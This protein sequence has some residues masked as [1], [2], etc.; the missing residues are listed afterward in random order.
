M[1][2]RV[3]IGADALVAGEVALTGAEHH[4]VARVRR[5]AVGDAITAFDGAGRRADGVIGAMT[6]DRTTLVLAAVVREPAPVPAIQSLVPL[7]KGDRLD[8]CVEKLAEV[9]VE[10]IALYAA[11]RA[12][13]RLDPERARTRRARLAAVAEAAARQSGRAAA[14]TVTGPMPLADALAAAAGCD[15]R[16]VAIP[17][18]DAP[19]APAEA[20][21]LA[22]LTGPEGGLTADELAAAAAAGFV[23]VG[24]GPHVLRAETAPIV[25]AGHAR[26]ASL[27]TVER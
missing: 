23:P 22:I 10:A 17:G 12:V 19:P 11:A 2:V 1:T 18:A 7:I 20:T 15:A 21:R 3:L 14:P 16:W 6:A 27:A 5:A 24:L 13:V 4:Y 25:A 9:G 26:I 8:L